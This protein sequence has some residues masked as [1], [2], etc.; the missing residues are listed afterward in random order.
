MFL[1]PKYKNWWN[2]FQFCRVGNFIF[3]LSMQIIKS[4]FGDDRIVLSMICNGRSFLVIPCLFLDLT[5][6][7]GSIIHVWVGFIFFYS[8]CFGRG[9]SSREGLVLEFT[10][11]RSLPTR[12][13]RKHNLVK[14]LLNTFCATGPT[15]WSSSYSP[16]KY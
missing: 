11:W 1:T 6:Y 13:T 4:V 12:S 16:I 10:L 5:I 7:Q 9:C 15:F 2:F 3:L 8:I 14:N